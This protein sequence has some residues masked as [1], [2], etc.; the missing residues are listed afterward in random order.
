[1]KR[2]IFIPNQTR[3]LL[4]AAW[5]ALSG[6]TPSEQAPSSESPLFDLEIID[7][8]GP[9]APW[10]KTLG[11]IDGDGLTDV[12]VGG[13][14][15]RSLTLGERLLRKLGLFQRQGR[16]GELIWYR[17]PTWERHLI[18]ENYK[19]R[20]DIE[21]ADI[22]A[23][24]RNDIVLVADQGVIWL[25][26]R[27]WTPHRISPLL[28]HDVAIEDLDGDGDLDIVGRNQSLFGH[29]DGHIVHIL[30]QDDRQRFRHI[31]LMTQHGEG[32][33][34]ADIDGDGLTDVVVNG[35]WLRNPGRLATDLDWSVFDYTLDWRWPDVFIDVADINHD[36]RNDIVLSPAEEAGQ[37]YRISWFEAP[38]D[39][40]TPWREHVID[41][42]VEAVH[43]FVAARDL[44][45]DGRLDV[46]TAEMNQGEGDNSVVAY[47]NRNGEWQKTTI[48]SLSSHS[49]RAQDIDND[50]DIDLV[51]TNWQIEGHDGDYPVYLW[52]N[53]LDSSPTWQRRV[54]DPD[55]PGRATFIK[56]ADLDGDGRTDLATGGVW[57]HQ[58]VRLDYRWTRQGFDEAAAN[59][60]LLHDVDTDGDVDVLAS[61]WRGFDQQPSLWQRLQHRL[62]IKPYRY[63]Q[64]GDEFV[65]GENDGTGQ[66]AVHDN[67]QQASGDFLQGSAILRETDG[68]EWV[69]L[70][71][72]R[73]GEGL[74]ALHIPPRP[75]VDP[76]SWRR[77]SPFSQDEAVSVVDLDGNGRQDILTGTAWLSRD[78]AGT[79]QRHWIVE[80]FDKPDRHQSVD[81][82]GDG[83]LDVIVGF[84]AV[85]R[86]GA[87]VVYLQ[88]DTFD[89]PWES[90]TLI[91]LIGPMSL[92]IADIDDDGDIDVVVGEHNLRAPDRSRLVWLE[93]PGEAD[94]DW[95]PHLIHQGDEHHNGALALDIDDD[96]DIDVA[97]IGWEHGKVIL[98]ENR[99]R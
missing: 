94:G 20:T 62:G 44:N 67:I 55:R 10:G 37:Y 69:L 73:E 5:F 76:W 8:S 60:L 83:R 54:I 53:R 90:R 11:D 35:Q 23:D 42:R 30:R 66:F 65:W 74:Q 36:G 56:A 12:V 48:S 52:R 38:V 92:D 39:P 2:R 17:N 91:T 64:R 88:P 47:M 16:G 26:G 72:H 7:P 81:I 33:G 99:A 96:G 46:V 3:F 13:H 29:H 85:S 77:L 63:G 1:M 95:L 19:I 89:A 25:D 28:L 50:F 80:T 22:N 84:E 40:T 71:W 79:W 49:M 70:S 98:Y 24:G 34:L 68:S 78:E 9:R 61:G 32:L 45:R 51:G 21:V 75:A 87:V 82:N 14:Q 57:Y 27:D 6:C 58:P 41:P 31:P 4:L 43:H 86:P 18:T 97:S 93:N 15:S 59:V